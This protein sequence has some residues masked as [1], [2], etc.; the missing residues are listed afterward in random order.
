MTRK[1]HASPLTA[2]SP[3]DGRY[4]G[5]LDALRPWLSEFGL[6]RCRVRV[7]VE[8]FIA[9]PRP[10]SPSWRRPAPPRSPSCAA[11][12]RDFS[13][14]DAEAIKAIERR[15]NHDVKAV[16]YWLAERFAGE[17]TLAPARPASSTSR[18][19][20]RTSTTPATR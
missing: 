12:S 10:A 3:L 19:P 5:K 17:P 20:A 11:W 4:A 13:V 9:L 15:T 2:L 6:M 1:M 16:E 8:W 18:A 14:A 7:E